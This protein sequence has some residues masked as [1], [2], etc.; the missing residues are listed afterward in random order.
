V[1]LDAL[2]LRVREAAMTGA[3][4]AASLQPQAAGEGPS[5]EREL[6]LIRVIE[7]QGDWNEQARQSLTA[8]ADCIRTLRDDWADERAELRREIGQLAALVAHLR[9][10]AT[11]RRRGK[12]Q[13]AGKRRPRS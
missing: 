1:D 4:G 11:P 8:L 13:P 9:P 3:G 5:R 2:M 12:V 6:D 7:A 10:A